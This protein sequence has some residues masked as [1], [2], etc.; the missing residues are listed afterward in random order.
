MFGWKRE[1]GARNNNNRYYT[2]NKI[3]LFCLVAVGTLHKESNDERQT[4][5]FKEWISMRSY[6]FIGSS[7]GG[8]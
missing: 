5:R 6:G 4:D 1:A 3:G 2:Q 7:S 8:M